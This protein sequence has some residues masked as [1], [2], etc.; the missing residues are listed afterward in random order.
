M[1][2]NRPHPVFMYASGVCWFGRRGW[3]R[4]KN[5][6]TLGTAVTPLHYLWHVPRNPNIQCI[7]SRVKH[8]LVDH[9]ERFVNDARRRCCKKALCNEAFFLF[10]EEGAHKD[11][12]IWY[13][14]IYLKFQRSKISN[15][16]PKAPK[17]LTAA[18][19]NPINLK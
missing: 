11:E 1:G 9:L 12:N 3:E 15:G 18:V 17:K 6:N 5:S 10:L 16:C 2:L 4:A 19:R 8:A 14:Y 13:C 7:I